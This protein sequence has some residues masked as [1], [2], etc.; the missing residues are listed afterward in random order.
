MKVKNTT[1]APMHIPFCEPS[2]LVPGNVGEIDV[3]AMKAA[4]KLAARIEGDIV[5]GKL[6]EVKDEAAPKP[7]K[8]AKDAK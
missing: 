4:P 3:E 6:E 7:A 5:A 8:P 2:L 1:L